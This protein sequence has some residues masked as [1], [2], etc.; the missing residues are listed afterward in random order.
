AARARVQVDGRAPRRS[1]TTSRTTLR[2][3]IIRASCMHGSDTEDGLSS[4][5]RFVPTIADETERVSH[6]RTEHT[7][8]SL[9]PTHASAQSLVGT[10]KHS[11]KAPL[12][13][14]GNFG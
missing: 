13:R 4:T 8:E 7:G 3:A 14:L 5:K 10:S 1:R 6:C 11:E 2:R 12:K 9:D